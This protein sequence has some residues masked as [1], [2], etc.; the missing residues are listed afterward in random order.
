MA[1]RSKAQA[2]ADLEG[3]IKNYAL[4]NAIVSIYKDEDHA[5]MKTAKELVSGTLAQL[6]EQYR[7]KNSDKDL[8]AFAQSLA[9]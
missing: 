5:D 6:I 4:L 2:K 8:E 1:K 9:S 7:S 3:V